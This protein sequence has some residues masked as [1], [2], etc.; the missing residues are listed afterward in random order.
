MGKVSN[1]YNFEPKGNYKS[2]SEIEKYIYDGVY[3]PIPD[4][5]GLVDLSYYARDYIFNYQTVTEI[6][7][8]NQRYLDSGIKPSSLYKAFCDCFGLKEIILNKFSSTEYL[9]NIASCFAMVDTGN[10]LAGN[11]NKID[12]SNWDTKNV[13]RMDNLFS[14]CRYLKEVKIE[15]L[16]L[17]NCTNIYFMFS[18]YAESIPIYLHF[19]NV[20]RSLNLSNTSGKEGITYIVDNY[21]D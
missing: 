20:P 2:Y 9:T 19:K 11:L 7:E 10:I 18:W 21:I 6:P 3:G 14:G 8:E 16:D 5:N 13:K 15:A 1:P 4:E 12:I 17:T